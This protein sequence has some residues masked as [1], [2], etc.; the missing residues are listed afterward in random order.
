MVSD[1]NENETD[2]ELSRLARIKGWLGENLWLIIGCVV[3][4]MMAPSVA[5]DAET[6][7]MRENRTRIEAMTQ[8]ERDLVLSNFESW[9]KLKKN[10]RDSLR[11]MHEA[12]S[13]DEDLS[14]TLENYHTWLASVSSD[15]YELRDRLLKEKDPQKRLRMIEGQFKRGGPGGKGHSNPGTGPSFVGPDFMVGLQRGPSLLG[16][17][18]EA[19]MVVIGDWAGVPK[20]PTDRVP[21]KMLKHHLQVINLAGDKLRTMKTSPRA[22]VRIPEQVV[23]D[24]LAAISNRQR[25]E[26][27]ALMIGD[28]PQAL[29]MLL[30]R[31]IRTEDIRQIAMTN[32]P[33]LEEYYKSMPIQRRRFVDRFQDKER[34]MRL[35]WMWVEEKVPSLMDTMRRYMRSNQVRPQ[36]RRP[37][38]QN[39]KHLLE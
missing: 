11:K 17:D 37:F 24:Y 15:S 32:S 28:D 27:I 13:K 6:P 25:R 8:T 21:M 26:E 2:P 9:R 33:L 35:A 31:S 4:L 39:G 30:M 16:R 34:M 10:E 22:S 5:K 19:V 23:E 29:L 1:P 7:E 14:R 38:N 20:P 18:F 12:V 36:N 3:V